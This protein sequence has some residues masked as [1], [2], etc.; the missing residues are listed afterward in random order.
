MNLARVDQNLHFLIFM[1]CT[2]VIS[3]LELIKMQILENLQHSSTQLGTQL[4]T[5]LPPAIST[6]TS[7][8]ITSFVEW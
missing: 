3:A 6:T 8:P 4:S 7:K 1:N 2:S 5:L